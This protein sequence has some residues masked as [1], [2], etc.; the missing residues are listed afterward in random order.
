M[1]KLISLLPLL[2]VATALL[3]Q[4]PPPE[5]PAVR[6]I[7]M[8]AKKYEYNPSAIQVRQGERVRL[9][10]KA[11]DRKHGF[12]IKKFG[13]KTE[14]EKGEETVVEFVADKAGTFQFKCSKWCGFGHGRM[15]GTLVV[16]PAE[17]K[18]DDSG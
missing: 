7:R 4:E 18:E 10:I 16:E 6:E 8:T 13:I 3:A 2:V 11:L 12:Q 5:E 14:L 15:R 17:S 9:I 1:K